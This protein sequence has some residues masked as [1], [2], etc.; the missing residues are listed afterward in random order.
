MVCYN[1]LGG[2]FTTFI[3]YSNLYNIKEKKGNKLSTFGVEHR[4]H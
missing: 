4:L 2:Y 3:I 1:I